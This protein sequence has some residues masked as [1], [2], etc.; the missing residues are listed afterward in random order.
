MYQAPFSDWV[1]NEV[2]IATMTVGAVTSADQVNTLIATGR[3]DLVALARTHL[4]NPYFTLQ[5]SAWYQHQAQEWPPQYLLGRDQAFRL[6]AR[7]RA[8]LTD[9]KLRARPASHEVKDGGAAP[10]SK[11]AA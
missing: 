10:G 2:G 9:L 3:A 7:E 1:R 6:A 5:A 11:R 8:E 4:T